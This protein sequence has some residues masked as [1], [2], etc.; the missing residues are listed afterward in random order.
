MLRVVGAPSVAIQPLGGVD[1]AALRGVADYLRS[2]LVADVTVL[3]PESLPPGAYYAPRRRYRGDELLDFLNRETP[4]SYSRVIGITSRDI[5]VT[6]GDVYDWGVFGVAQLSGRPGMVST[7][8][9]RAH[10]ASSRLAQIRLD[11][12]VLHELG[13]TLGLPHCPVKGC[14]MQDA[15]GSI[16][17]VDES[18]GHFCASCAARLLSLLQ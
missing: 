15:N 16:R 10:A 17:T 9:L 7:Y 11:T 6:S 3:P 14:V 8:R 4:A 5:S 12:V 1:P 2:T 18:T 13:H